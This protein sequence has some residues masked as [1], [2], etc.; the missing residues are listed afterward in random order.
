MEDSEVVQGTPFYGSV[1]EI[2]VLNDISGREKLGSWLAF[3]RPSGQ[4]VCI[5]DFTLPKVFLMH[6]LIKW[7]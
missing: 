5:K 1:N 3:Q 7:S 4:V 6:M 2:T